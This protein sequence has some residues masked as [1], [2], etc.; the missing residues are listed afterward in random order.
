[1]LAYITTTQARPELPPPSS[2]PESSATG[3]RRARSQSTTPQFSWP[4]DW[5]IDKSALRQ[6]IK[7]FD[8]STHHILHYVDEIRRPPSTG[9]TPEQASE[10]TPATA[11]ETDSINSASET[12]SHNRRQ[13]TGQ[14]TPPLPP[15]HNH[16]QQ[17]LPVMDQAQIQQM[18]TAAVQAAIQALPRQQGPPGPPGP[19]GPPGTSNGSTG[20]GWQAAD[21]GYFDPMLDKSYGE[22]EVVTVGKDVYYRSVIL[23]VERI[24]DL[25]SVKGATLV[26][27][28]VNTCLRGAALTWY[29]AELSNLERVGLRADENDV[30]EWCDA[31]T[32]RF[33][34]PTGVA[35]T[36]LTSEKYTLHDARTRREPASYVQAILRHAKAAN[37]N[38]VEHQ[39][40]FAY[41][42]IA[43]E[44]RAFIDP[45][46][47]GITI[48]SFIQILE[49]KKDTWFEMRFPSA[50]TGSSNQ[51]SRQ[52]LQ[53]TGVNN[54]LQRQPFG[55]Y[56]NFN[57]PFQNRGS[58]PQFAA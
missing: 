57:Q 29:T 45:P 53:Q 46:R 3:E 20:G 17:P 47:A 7:A 56:R 22:G 38:E 11:T 13:S 24:K 21:L 52:P 40:T 10:S 9:N 37:F 43:A 30:K 50:T 18:I 34:Q 54:Q 15:V 28:N 58:Q 49:L 23:F 5:S 41:Q 14:T 31:L 25:A 44:L 36:Q 42:G 27:S 32:K 16:Q 33:K 1:M 12:G 48:A 6:A 2:T 8:R 51:S 35:L 4:S 19:A 39:L 55:G 26:R